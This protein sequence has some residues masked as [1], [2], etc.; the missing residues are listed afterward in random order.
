MTPHRDDGLRADLP[1]IRAAWEALLFQVMDGR[2]D[3]AGAR[4]FGRSAEWGE[5]LRVIHDR[6]GREALAARDPLTRFFIL[7]LRGQKQDF[8]WSRLTNAGA[9][10][11]ALTAFSPLVPLL[12]ENTLGEIE[13]VDDNGNPLLCRLV[14][15]S[16]EPGH[17]AV[18]RTEKGQWLI[19]PMAVY[20]GLAKALADY[21]EHE[22]EGDFDAFIAQYLED[23]DLALDLDKAWAAAHP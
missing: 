21:I 2:A 20:D 23:A 15:G 4:L 1:A 16:P 22:F 7:R 3:A 10:A 17:V 14:A 13:D 11:L 5:S 9:F 12:A 6:E 8:D 19:D 18:Q